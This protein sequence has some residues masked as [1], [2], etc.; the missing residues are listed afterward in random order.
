MNKNSGEAEEKLKNLFQDTLTIIDRAISFMM[1]MDLD[2]LANCYE[3]KLDEVI[4]D[5]EK[6]KKLQYVGGKFIITYATAE[7]FSLRT[8][9]YF[10][11]ENDQWEKAEA[12][13]SKYM[14][15]LKPRAVKELEEKTKIIYDIEPPKKSEMEIK[16]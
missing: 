1:Q 13:T 3:K 8:E 10:L 12:L 14:K 6:K 7:L 2:E 5:I 15:F 16:E 4:L 11:N 9:L